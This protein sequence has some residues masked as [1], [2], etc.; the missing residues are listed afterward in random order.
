MKKS[1][2]FFAL[3]LCFQSGFGQ[4]ALETE[5]VS[6]S[7]DTTSVIRLPSLQRLLDHIATASPRIRKAEALIAKTKHQLSR[8]K[9]N[10]LDAISFGV[11]STY[12]SYGND[13]LDQISLGVTG[14]LTVRLS[15]FDVFSRKSQKGIMQEELVVTE[16][17]RQVVEREER[18]ILITL[19]R[20]HH[21]SGE[22]VRIK[23]DAW[24]AAELHQK[25]AETEFTQGDIPVSEL[26]RVTEIAMKAEAEF[27]QSR[28]MYR[29]SRAVLENFVGTSLS[30]IGR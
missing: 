22:M 5:I 1:V 26:A 21:L 11:S 8:T 6:S 20:E 16:S 13:V 7:L 23:S 24:S 28:A 12:G 10:W 17:N 27:E 19:Y 2:L 9:L 4:T 18:R 14:G 3:T 25:M 30:T 15:L 29:T